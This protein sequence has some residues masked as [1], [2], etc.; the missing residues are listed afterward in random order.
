MIGGQVCWECLDN[1]GRWEAPALNLGGTN[2]WPEL[3]PVCM[4]EGSQLSRAIKESAKSSL[5]LTMQMTPATVTS[6]Q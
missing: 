2:S 6:L 1:S 3:C 5:T 4:S